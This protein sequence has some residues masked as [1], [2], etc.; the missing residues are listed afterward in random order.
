M[1]DT[2][3]PQPLPPHELMKWLTALCRATQATAKSAPLV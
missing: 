3:P 2:K 1:A